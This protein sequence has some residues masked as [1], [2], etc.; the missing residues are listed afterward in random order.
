M[1]LIQRGE[2]SRGIM[3][4]SKTLSGLKFA[5]ERRGLHSS[6]TERLHELKTLRAD[7]AP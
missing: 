3:L 1:T 7:C 6:K 2:E 5:A 4:E